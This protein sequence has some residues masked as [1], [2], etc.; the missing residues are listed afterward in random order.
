M[1]LP[2][3]INKLREDIDKVSQRE[4]PRLNSESVGPTSMTE[5]IDMCQLRQIES[6]I[7]QTLYRIDSL[8]APETETVRLMEHLEMWKKK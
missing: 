4:V 3:D 8:T 7:H 5:F 1:K 2:L 6:N